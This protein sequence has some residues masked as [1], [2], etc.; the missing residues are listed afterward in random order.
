M[1]SFAFETPVAVSVG[2]GSR[3][4]VRSLM[5]MHRFLQD[6]PHARRS[7]VYATATRACEAAKQG[8]LTTE[9][10]RRAFVSFAKCHDILWPDMDAVIA[11]STTG[12]YTPNHA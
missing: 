11:G 2:L 12:S 1:N 9:Q 7:S 4:E 3:L 8:H 10:A 6:W 5:D